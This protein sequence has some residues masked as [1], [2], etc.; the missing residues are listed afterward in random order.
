VLVWQ[1][2]A[3]P[4]PVRDCC[5]C[6]QAEDVS[7]DRCLGTA[8]PSSY[9]AHGHHARCFHTS[10]IE[11]GICAPQYIWHST[12]DKG[13]HVAR[14]ALMPK[15]NVTKSVLRRPIVYAKGLRAFTLPYGGDDQQHSLIELM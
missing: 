15:R 13:A 9:L 3:G 12:V 2:V 6:W 1:V 11:V 10:L 7:P 5:I 8:E 4:L 14:E